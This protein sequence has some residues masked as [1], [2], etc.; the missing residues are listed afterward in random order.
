MDIQEVKVMSTED[1]MEGVVDH[2][3][4]GGKMLRVR[5]IVRE[6]GGKRAIKELRITGDFFLH[7]R[8]QQSRGISIHIQRDCEV[9][10]FRLCIGILSSSRVYL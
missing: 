3:V 1:L 6:E 2:K 4:P 8:I 5:V 9:V 7:P 10:S